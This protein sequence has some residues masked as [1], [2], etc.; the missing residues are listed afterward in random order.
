M[1]PPEHYDL[2]RQQWD[3]APFV[4]R[5]V[6]S[7]L[8]TDPHQYL[9]WLHALSGNATTSVPRAP[10]TAVN[11]ATSQSIAAQLPRPE[12]YFED[13]NAASQPNAPPEVSGSS[14]H[15]HRRHPA[16]PK[17]DRIPAGPFLEKFSH[18]AAWKPP[19]KEHKPKRPVPDVARA[20]QVD[21]VFGGLTQA[22]AT[23][24]TSL[25]RSVAQRAAPVAAAT[26][27][28]RKASPAPPAER[29]AMRPPGRST[30]STVQSARDASPSR[31]KAPTSA[32]PTQRGRTA[33]VGG[34][35]IADTLGGN[36]PALQ[37][38]RSAT[39]QL[40]GDGETSTERAI[41]DPRSFL[42]R[43]PPP[44]RV[45]VR[46]RSAR[47]PLPPVVTEPALSEA[48]AAYVAEASRLGPQPW[49]AYT[50]A[51]APDTRSF[52][53]GGNADPFW[54][55]GRTATRPSPPGRGVR[56]VHH[57]IPG[58]DFSSLPDRPH[59]AA[60]AAAASPP[61]PILRPAS[62]R[63][64]KTPRSGR[65]SSRSMAA[66]TG[67][68]CATSLN[69]LDVPGRARICGSRVAAATTEPSCG[70]A[71]HRQAPAHGPASARLLGAGAAAGKTP[72]SRGATLNELAERHGRPAAI[73][74]SKPSSHVAAFNAAA[75]TEV[76]RRTKAITDVDR[77]LPKGGSRT[78]S[79]QTLRARAALEEHKAHQ[80]RMAFGGSPTGARAH[81]LRQPPPVPEG[82][83][84]QSV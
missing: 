27:A 45:R 58:T 16:V 80:A 72:R 37:G 47:N 34:F 82:K 78:V 32:I 39:D 74:V 4:N 36:H 9:G 59:T 24:S 81:S 33:D 13:P 1:L 38:S 51:P 46:P 73:A 54:H 5:G 19:V 65:S 12:V 71:S 42:P 8:S 18:Y 76:L 67:S 2:Q 50:T 41:L 48:V 60:S 23:P 75:A 44:P 7:S 22:I 29:T 35:R 84:V 28:S 70:R 43:A 26:R 17:L 79:P 6:H 30:M 55:L 66:I 11:G 57:T 63:Q 56:N 25:P 49:R 68:V 40:E 77:G 15:S 3:R 83:V 64:F 21:A 69:S 14:S 53:T 61:A 52:H 62:A 31:G 10:S 20:L